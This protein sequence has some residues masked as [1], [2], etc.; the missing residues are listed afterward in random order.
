MDGQSS[1]TPN[2]V[3]LWLVAWPNTGAH[4]ASDRFASYNNRALARDW[5]V[6]I[7]F[8]LHFLRFHN[9]VHTSILLIPAEYDIF[10]V[11]QLCAYNE[12][13]PDYTVHVWKI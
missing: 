8:L 3:T 12:K 6:Y 1:P 4:S 5:H 13:D 7:W 11:L 10:K 2:H 9:L